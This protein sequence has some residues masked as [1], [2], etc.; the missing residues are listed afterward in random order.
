[1]RLRVR[2]AAS[3]VSF[4][5]WSA[6]GARSHYKSNRCARCF[7]RRLGLARV[8]KRVREVELSRR[9]VWVHLDRLS[10]L[11]R[12]LAEVAEEAERL[13][14]VAPCGR[15]PRVEGARGCV[16]VVGES[17]LLAARVPHALRVMLLR[18]CRWRTHS[19][20]LLG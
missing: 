7:N 15:M 10:E 8:A 4:V 20:P 19:L 6:A 3:G 17:M 11:R 2:D 5:G 14:E 18:R 9:E 12:R 16:A 13:P 1:M